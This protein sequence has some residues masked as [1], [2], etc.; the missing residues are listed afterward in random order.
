MRK[1]YAVGV[2]VALFVALVLLAV[3]VASRADP[4]T[5]D[6]AVLGVLLGDNEISSTGDSG[7]GDPD[8]FGSAA[9]VVDGNQLCFGLTVKNLDPPVAAHIHSGKAGENG[10]VVVPL[11]P[12]ASGDPGTSSGCVFVDPAL[13]DVLLSHPGEYYWN[14]HT[15]AFPGGAI[16]GQVF[17]DKK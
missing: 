17:L 2:A 7:V 14:V 6:R 3:P 15:G 13:L 11:A 16:R 8:G 4:Q 5:G 9:G 10:P 12:P 1:Q